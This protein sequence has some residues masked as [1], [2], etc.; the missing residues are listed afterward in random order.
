MFIA[1]VFHNMSNSQRQETLTTPALLMSVI[2]AKN[3]LH[4]ID[5]GYGNVREVTRESKP[6]TKGSYVS[7][8]SGAPTQLAQGKISFS[9]AI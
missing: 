2:T 1:N 5:L 4:H 3:S 9:M 6:S 8:T 7:N